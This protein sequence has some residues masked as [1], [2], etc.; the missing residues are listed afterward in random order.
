MLTASGEDA[1][2]CDRQPVDKLL[3]TPRRHAVV[4]A[5]ARVGGYYDEEKLRHADQLA[6]TRGNGAWSIGAGSFQAL[7]A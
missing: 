3:E 6:M 2:L 4:L 7:S 1:D 5:A